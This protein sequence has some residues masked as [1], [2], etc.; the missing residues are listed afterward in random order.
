ML[1]DSL[2]Y[3]ECWVFLVSE[4]CED[5]LSLLMKPDPGDGIVTI[6]CELVTG[7]CDGIELRADVLI[8]Y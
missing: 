4:S 1:V 3:A 8:S 7:V 5:E 6:P 2:L